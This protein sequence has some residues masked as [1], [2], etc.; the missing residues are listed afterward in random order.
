MPAA[1]GVLAGG[2]ALL[3]ACLAVLGH[4]VGEIGE[5]ESR[6]L[7][8]QVNPLLHA[9]A[10]PGM[11]DLMTAITSLGAIPVVPVV[12]GLAAGML[13]I[14]RRRREAAFLVVAVAG[15]VALNLALKLVI[16]RPRPALAWAQAMPDTSFPSGHTQ[17]AVALYVALALVAWVVAGRRTGQVALVLAV[18]ISA[19]VGL[20]RLYL[21]VHYL[22]D[23]LAGAVA[24]VAWLLVV[25]TAFEAG[26]AL[27][28][29]REPA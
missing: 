16:H 21:G 4:L 23:V 11:D 17:T 15:S 7:D 25:G 12:L 14:A 18:V 19:A 5:Q 10:S 3:V 13:A 27:R 22:T 24:G 2:F 26:P 9:L 29:W 28:G 1:A 20:S 8:T 6:A